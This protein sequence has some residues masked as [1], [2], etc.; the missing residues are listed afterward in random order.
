MY[1]LRLKE[2]RKER[3][4][5]QIEMSKLL[6]VRQNTYSQYE[7]GVNEPSLEILIK[8]SDIFKVPLDYLIQR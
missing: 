8:I 7:T 4:L 5:T 2:I 1:N 6:N 3:H